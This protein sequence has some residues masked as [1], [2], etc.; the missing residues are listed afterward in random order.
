MTD[1]SGLVAVVTGGG[2]GLGLI[3]ARSLEE[4]G[5]KVFIIGR[6]QE[7]L[8]AAS[9]LAVSCVRGVIMYSD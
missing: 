1:V 7:K 4:N 5:A 3:V 8:E 6:R 2:T 9:K